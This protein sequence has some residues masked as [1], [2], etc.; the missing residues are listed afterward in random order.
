MGLYSTGTQVQA[1]TGKLG[2]SILNHACMLPIKFCM[3]PG[4]QKVFS[5]QSID[6]YKERKIEN[7]KHRH[8]V[9]IVLQ[10]ANMRNSVSSWILVLTSKFYFLNCCRFDICLSFGNSHHNDK[11]KVRIIWLLKLYTFYHT[12]QKFI[13]SSL[14]SMSIQLELSV[15]QSPW[16]HSDDQ[17]NIL[18]LLLLLLLLVQWALFVLSLQLLPSP[19][20]LT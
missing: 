4:Q 3:L 19:Q 16:Q 2:G 17:C 9:E 6:I 13:F 11:T 7:L 15:N 12:R 10:Y 20:K 14:T 1:W 5:I 18:L 8:L